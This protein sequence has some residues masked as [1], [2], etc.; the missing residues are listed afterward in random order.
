LNP[1][2]P[3]SLLQDIIR[4]SKQ[5]GEAILR[6]YGREF[7]VV[8]KDD[9]SPLTAADL[10]S[11]NL[12]RDALR[13]LTPRIPLLSEES[14]TVDFANRSAWS[15]YWLVDPLDGTKEFIKRNGE[16]RQHCTGAQPNR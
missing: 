1:V 2:P 11:H 5:A 7:D 12:I 15:E 10:A 13:R 8:H 6:I 4:I 14:A 16:Y 9:A 3:E